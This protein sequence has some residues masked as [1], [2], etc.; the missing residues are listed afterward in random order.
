MLSGFRQGRPIFVIPLHVVAGFLESDRSRRASG[1]RPVNAI[2]VSRKLMGPEGQPG[3]SVLQV[4][5]YVNITTVKRY[6]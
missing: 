6:E 2:A 4:Y 3:C 5:K 1:V